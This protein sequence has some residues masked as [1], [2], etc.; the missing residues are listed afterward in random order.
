M[1]IVIFMN[2]DTCT[3][4]IHKD[5]KFQILMFKTFQISNEILTIKIQA[6]I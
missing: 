6:Y 2:H 5:P 1:F 4:Y 3:N